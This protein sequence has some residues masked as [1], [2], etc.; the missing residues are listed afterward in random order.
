MVY[1]SPRIQDAG[2]ANRVA[3]EHW[4]STGEV[5]NMRL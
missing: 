5:F 2:G 3:Q 1:K 4:D